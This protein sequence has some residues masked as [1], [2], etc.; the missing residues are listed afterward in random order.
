M[1]PQIKAFF[2]KTTFTITYVIFD[3]STR[4]AIVIDPVL[5]YDHAASKI[6]YESIE[7]V[8][9]FTKEN[10]LKVHYILETHAHADHLTGAAELKRRLGNPFVAI[11]KNIIKVQEIFK[12][13]YNMKSLNPNGEQFDEL[14]NDGQSIEAGSLKVEVIFTPGH[15]PA[16]TTFKNRG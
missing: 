13:L 14:L 10:Q 9:S 5:D 11:N 7:L 12:D 6:T 4:D 8:E 16:C 15:T 2:D 3:E 1:T